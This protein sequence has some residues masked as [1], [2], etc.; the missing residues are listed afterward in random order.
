MIVGL[1]RAQVVLGMPWLMKNNPCI[2]WVKKTIS[3]NDEHIQKTTLSTELAI[4]TQKNEVVLPLQY[5]D[6][7]D[8]FSK[9]TFDV[10]PPRQDFDHAIELKELF[11]PKVTK[12]YPL[13]PQEVEACQ[14]FIEENLKMG[15]IQPSKSPQA[16]PF[17]FIKKKDGKLRPVQDYRYLNDHTIK[18]AYPLPLISDLIDNLQ[19]FLCFTKFNVQWG[20]NNI[21]IKEGDEWKAAFLILMGLFKPTVMFFRL[22]RSPL[23]F[24]AFMNFNFTDYICEGWLVIYMDDLVIGATSEEDEEQKVCLVLQHFCNLRLSLK[25]SKCEFSKTEVEFLGMVVG[26]GCIH[27]DPAKLSAIA[28][29]PPLKTVKAVHSFLSFCNFYRKFIPGFSNTVAP[30]TALTHKNQ[31][32]A[33]GPEQQDAFA[34]LLSHFQT[35]PV[36]HLPDVRH[37]FIV[38]TNASL[39]ASGGVLMQHD[40]NGDLHPCTTSPRHS[41]LQS[42]I[43]TSMIANYLLLFMPLTTGAITFR[44]PAT[45]SPYLPTTKI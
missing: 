21:C 11:V 32:W 23:T 15:W 28:S 3:F 38:M 12:I 10:L 7:A 8:V 44:V 24:Q 2:N 43:M 26:S 6:Y 13:N 36:L 34:T 1:G 31:P 33:W 5:E 19:Q 20:Y 37:P 40:D 9:R 39:L 16:S 25:L 30:L 27:M 45:L 42:A 41:L 29:W 14:E 22:C 35:A 18:N 4:A 17:F